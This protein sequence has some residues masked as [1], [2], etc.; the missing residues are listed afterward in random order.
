MRDKIYF[1][2]LNGLRFFAALSVIFFHLGDTELLGA[3][4][5][6][7]FLSHLL[8]NG[9]DAVTLFFVLSGF[10]ITY[11]LLAELHKTDTVNVRKFYV[12]RI[13][14]IWPLYYFMVF[15]GFVVIP[16]IGI[17]LNSEALA[18][19]WTLPIFS[20]VLKLGLYLVM[21][22]H[23]GIFFLHYA[24]G[25]DQLWSIGV[26]ENF[27]LIW[28][29]L[30]K[31]F[32]KRMVALLTGIIVIKLACN[33]I[34]VVLEQNPQ[35]PLWL[36]HVFGLINFIRIENMAVGGLGAYLVFH[37]Y[38]RVL[39]FVFHPIVDK[40]ILVIIVAN[41][42]LF[43]G[44]FD[45]VINYLLSLVY[46]GLILNVT[47]NPKPTLKLEYPFFDTLGRI[48]YGMYMYHVAIIYI[49]SAVLANTFLVQT[50]TVIGNFILYIGVSLTT[51]GV[52]Y[53]SYKYLE[54]PFLRLKGRF[55]VIKSGESA[56]T[57]AQNLPK[58]IATEPKT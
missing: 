21:L 22:P 54:E 18:W 27:Y 3:S 33:L 56:R 16:L 52:A 32:R 9:N 49:A 19:L 6:G 25:I 17:V 5:K 58:N 44:Q 7:F 28:P 42:L 37:N 10:L 48:S 30:V 57:R 47:C 4:K 23:V 39:N 51:I 12:R 1:P 2:G 40:L 41:I 46:I 36:L 45:W 13:L 26:E 34:Y 15:I 8:M 38:R 31:I 11:L 50:D 53:L 14:R 55:T 35:T 20:I 29:V 43:T 24:P